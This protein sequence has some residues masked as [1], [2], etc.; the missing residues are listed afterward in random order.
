[1]ALKILDTATFRRVVKKLHPQ[2]KKIVDNAIREIAVDPTIGQEKK[3]DL[4]DVFVYKFKINK[5]E[6]LMSYR[7]RPGKLDPTEIVLLSLGTHE[8][9]YSDLKRQAS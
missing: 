8:N 9:F 1:M 5:Q 3:G 2:D 7:L 4:A 6:T